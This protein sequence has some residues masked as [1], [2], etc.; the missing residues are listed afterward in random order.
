MLLALSAN[1]EP[2]SSAFLGCSLAYRESRGSLDEQW[3]DVDQY[4][5]VPEKLREFV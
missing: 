1:R 2:N 5:K 4:Q 3:R